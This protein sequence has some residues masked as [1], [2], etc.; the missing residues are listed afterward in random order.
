VVNAKRLLAG[1]AGIVALAALWS[2][3]ASDRRRISAR[4]DEVESLFD[5]SGPEDQ[6]TAFGRTRHIVAAF[7][8]GFVVQA[9]PYEGSISDLQQL[10]G[11][12]QGYR[13]SSSRIDVHDSGRATTVDSKRG[14]AE[15]TTVFALAGDRG[16][17]PG[18]ERF[19]ARIAWVELDGEWKIQE[20]EIL[21]V[22]ERGGML[23]F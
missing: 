2:W 18:T 3:W 14:T 20:F 13:E 10:A 21:E 5:K 17:G 15:T 11:V 19:R 9:R 4:L 1:L 22:L 12:V 6:L 8:P 16:A 7:A 23:G